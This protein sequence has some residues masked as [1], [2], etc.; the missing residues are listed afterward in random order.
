MKIITIIDTINKIPSHKQFQDLAIELV[1]QGFKVYHFSESR[2]TDYNGVIVF[3]YT[4]KKGMLH[5]LFYFFQS[6]LKIKPTLVI[7]TFRGSFFVDIL[8]YIFNFKWFAFYQSDYYDS[9]FINKLRYRRVDLFFVLSS[10]MVPKIIRMYPHLSSKIKIIPN[11]FEFTDENF[12][13]KQEIILHVG[14]FTK[15]IN[16]AFV[17]GTDLLIQAFLIWINSL[18]LNEIPKLIIIGEGPFKNQ[19]Y[20]LALDNNN[21]VFTGLLPHNEVLTYMKK[22]KILVQPS[23]NEAFG[24]VFLEAMNYGCA[25]IGTYNTGAE[26]IIIPG[27]YGYLVHQENIEDL[28]FALNKNYSFQKVKETYKIKREIFTREK[29]I[30]SMLYNVKNIL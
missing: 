25:L 27:K 21:I 16:G 2:K 3:N 17:K 26:D 22:S 4:L 14:G 5:V 24:N 9:K 13:E 20:E 18:K 7:S 30:Q 23:R 1:R 12:I 6:F 15:N 28:V 19:L 11:S 10:P 8:S 29:W